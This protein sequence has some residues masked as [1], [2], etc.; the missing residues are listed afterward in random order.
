[1]NDRTLLLLSGPTREHLDPVRYLSNASS[2]IMG[3]ALADEALARGWRV[4][5]VTG[6]VDEARIPAGDGLSVHRVISAAEM[7]ARSR[8]LF[9]RC[10]A[11]I[12]AAAVADFRPATVSAQKLSKA[13]KALTLALEPTPDIASELAA[14]KARGQK[15]VGFAL[16]THDGEE[17]ARAKLRAKQ[18]DAIVLNTVEAL[19]AERARYAVLRAGAKDFE[20]WG[21][22]DKRACA[23]RILDLLEEVPP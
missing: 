7:L 21:L 2:G 18:L 10:R 4:D 20:P 15:T 14:R 19:G 6:P 22:L 9:G 16:Q 11:A 17:R 13:E 3:R 5:F 8:D 23:A 12:F 1:M